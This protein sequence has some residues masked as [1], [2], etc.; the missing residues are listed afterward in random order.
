MGSLFSNL[1]SILCESRKFGKEQD[2]TIAHRSI[3]GGLATQFQ[4]YKFGILLLILSSLITNRIYEKFNYNTAQKMTF[5]IKDFFS[6]C[7]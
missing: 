2:L 6:K 7:D 3:Y 5:S 4:I 1:Y